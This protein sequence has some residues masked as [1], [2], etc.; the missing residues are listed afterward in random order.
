MCAEFEL[1]AAVTT[2]SEDMS[3][4]HNLR[5]QGQALRRRVKP[6]G[7]LLQI[8]NST[9]MQSSKGQT[10]ERSAQV[11]YYPAYLIR[12][13]YG[14]HQPD[15]NLAIQ[16]QYHEALVA[17][18]ATPAGVN[19]IADRHFS[20]SKAQ[21]AAAGAVVAAKA[22]FAT[23]TGALAG[24]ATLAALVSKLLAAV[25]TVDTAF[26][27]FLAASAAR[28]AAQGFTGFMRERRIA[29][30]QQ[31]TTEL[32]GQYMPGGMS[33]HNIEGPND[34][35][36]RA[37]AEWLRWEGDDAEVWEPEKRR[38]WAERL[39][40]EQ[41]DRACATFF[42]LACFGTAR[43]CVSVDFGYVAHHPF[44]TLVVRIVACNP[45]TFM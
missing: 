5:N 18:A 33:A 13:P 27:A 10:R 8:F 11:L 3:V 32:H 43:L 39:L 30:V 15:G 38:A 21:A 37:D 9:A 31:R 16:E 12:Y 7:T 2:P 40:R 45:G 26:V 28:V 19:V 20:A 42:D 6:R 17:A 14:R 4:P 23:A 24:S 44:Y 36:V 34:L 22:T 35:W 1:P 25:S 29:R 41:R